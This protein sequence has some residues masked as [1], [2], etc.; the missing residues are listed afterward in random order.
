MIR[1]HRSEPAAS[2]LASG[3]SASVAR[4]QLPSCRGRDGSR[5]AGA[6]RP[7]RRSQRP[8]HGMECTLP[9]RRVERPRRR[10]SCRQLRRARRRVG[11]IGLTD[12]LIHHEESPSST[13]SPAIPIPPLL[14]GLRS[15]VR[16][17]GRRLDPIPASPTNRASIASTSG[18][19]MD[20]R[21]VGT[22]VGADRPFVRPDGLAARSA[23]ERGGA[24]ARWP[25]RHRGRQRSRRR[26]PGTPPAGRRTWGTSRDPVAGDRRA[27]LVRSPRL[28]VAE[29]VGEE[30]RK[31]VAV[32]WFRDAP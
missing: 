28:V 32:L 20:P 2:R 7:R 8:R 14:S 10:P 26:P 12:T 25:S 9:A 3:P 21:S 17:R 29:Q 30:R 18:R 11:A 1:S 19:W 22:A 16:E 23:R 31:P 6:R 5:S 15:D 24:I 27:G 13:P 4:H